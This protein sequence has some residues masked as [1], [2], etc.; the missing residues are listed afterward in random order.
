MK[1]Y[2][3]YKQIFSLKLAGFLMM[4]GIPIKRI[5]HNLKVKNKDVYLFE[6]TPEL[7]QVMLK[8][9]KVITDKGDNYDFKQNSKS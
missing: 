6:D 9:K 4:N 2:K 1:D 7:T 8:Y 5:H 3:M